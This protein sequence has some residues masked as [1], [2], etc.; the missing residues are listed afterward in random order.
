MFIRAF[1]TMLAAHAVDR[2]MRDQQHQAW[3]ADY[4]AR[5]ANAAGASLPQRAP[6]GYDPVRPER[7]T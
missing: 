5:A 7:P 3:L 4:E 6:M 2:H 1:I